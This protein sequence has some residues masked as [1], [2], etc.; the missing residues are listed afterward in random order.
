MLF[1]CVGGMGQVSFSGSCLHTGPGSKGPTLLW[2]SNICAGSFVKSSPRMW[3]CA[4]KLDPT[5]KTLQVAC[6][7]LMNSCLPYTILVCS[8]PGCVWRKSYDM[9]GRCWHLLHSAPTVLSDYNCQDSNTI[10]SFTCCAMWC[11]TCSLHG[12]RS[13]PP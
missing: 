4:A 6:T 8:F 7:I 12:S 10:Q 3:P 13:S 9:D 11:T 2:L 1:G 5:W